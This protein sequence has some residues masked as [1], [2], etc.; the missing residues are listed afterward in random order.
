MKGQIDD[1]A[2]VIWKQKFILR[3]VE[4]GL[5]AEDGTDAYD[6]GVPD[7]DYEYDP[8]MAA[9]DELSYWGD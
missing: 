4:V 6:A 8:V 1:T 9:D 5:T 3:F 7:H 2:T